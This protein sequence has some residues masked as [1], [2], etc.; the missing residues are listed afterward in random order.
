ME[1]AVL[2]RDWYWEAP[3]L[4]QGANGRALTMLAAVT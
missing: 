4:K 1:G 2:K 3:C